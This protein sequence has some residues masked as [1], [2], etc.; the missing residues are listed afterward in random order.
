MMEWFSVMEKG[1]QVV[2]LWLTAI[3]MEQFHQVHSSSILQEMIF[4]DCGMAEFGI[5]FLLGL[6]L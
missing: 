4:G 6:I 1:G 3:Q 5:W 2:D